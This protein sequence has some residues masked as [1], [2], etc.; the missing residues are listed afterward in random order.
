[1]VAA[2]LQLSHLAHIFVA[3]LP[4]ANSGGY[5]HQPVFPQISCTMADL[6]V[7]IVIGLLA[8]TPVEFNV[9]FSCQLKV[10]LTGMPSAPY[11]RRLGLASWSKAYLPGPNVRA[12]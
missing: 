5:P 9:Y 4:A 7:P 3:S 11:T 6:R 8:N 1:M 12:A 10:R 2:R